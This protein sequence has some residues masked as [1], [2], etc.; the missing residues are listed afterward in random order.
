[1]PGWVGHMDWIG[2]LLFCVGGYLGCYVCLF[3]PL[4]W[5]GGEGGRRGQIIALP[6]YFVFNRVL[7]GWKLSQKNKDHFGR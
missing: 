1:M 2:L 7:V 5:E 4:G 6:K 3:G